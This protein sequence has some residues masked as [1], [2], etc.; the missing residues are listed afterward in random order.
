MALALVFGKK[1]LEGRLAPLT[2][3]PPQPLPPAPP[4]PH[5]TPTSFPLHPRKAPFRCK[6]TNH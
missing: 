2:Q 3:P 1:V 4:A 6:G 5:P